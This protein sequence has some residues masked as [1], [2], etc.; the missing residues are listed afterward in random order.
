MGTMEVINL[1]D[2][3]DNSLFVIDEAPITEEVNTREMAR[4]R[5][6]SLKK[7]NVKKAKQ[8][9]KDEVNPVKQKNNYV[10]MGGALPDNNATKVKKRKSL[11]TIVID[12]DESVI[13][14][15]DDEFGVIGGEVSASVEKAQQQMKDYQIRC[16]QRLGQ[17][18]S[19][20]VEVRE[21]TPP[22]AMCLKKPGLSIADV[23]AAAKRKLRPIV[24]DGSNIAFGHGDSRRQFS[25]KGI[26]ICAQFFQ[27]RGHT[28]KVFV[29]QFRRR[30]QATLDTHILDKLEEDKILVYTPSRHVNGKTVVSYDD[31]MM[32]E[33]AAQCGAVIV[34]RDNLRDLASESEVYKKVIDERLL[35]FTWVDDDVIMFPQDPLGRNGPCLDEFLSFPPEE[36]EKEE[37]DEKSSKG[38]EAKKPT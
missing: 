18:V 10:V 11:E 13:E 38:D 14:L 6:A 22:R 12:D 33:Y 19:E 16:R 3:A 31:R 30:H 35:M 4:K 8:L 23:Q 27:R 21:K 1:D 15:S 29:P 36:A 37:K 24:I 17:K 25:S 26:E 9:R 34:T 5:K 28:V 2:T 20:I 7:K 32:V